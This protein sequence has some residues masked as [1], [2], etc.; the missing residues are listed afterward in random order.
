MRTLQPP[1]V[2]GSCQFFI[3]AQEEAELGLAV[4]E[5]VVA[6]MTGGLAGSCCLECDFLPVLFHREMHG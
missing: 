6:E 4:M 3:S 1:E 5:A 2:T